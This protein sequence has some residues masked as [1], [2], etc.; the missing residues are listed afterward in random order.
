[1]LWTPNKIPLLRV[2]VGFLAAGLSGRN[3]RM[4]LPAVAL[5]VTAIALDALDGHI[6]RK[7]RL[8]TPTENKHFAQES[9]YIE[10]QI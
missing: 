5:T 8:A 4:N 10:G 1:M 6:A 9:D 7:K 2:G 3:A